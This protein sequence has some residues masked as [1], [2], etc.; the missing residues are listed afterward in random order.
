[1]DKDK[2]IKLRNTVKDQA[3]EITTIAGLSSLLIYGSNIEMVHGGIVPQ[4][5]IGT[6]Y[7][8]TTIGAT[9]QATKIIPDLIDDEINNID[10]NKVLKRTK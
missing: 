9:Y 4:V 3:Q 2:L 7:I 8:G 1:M 6:I 10:N 5:V